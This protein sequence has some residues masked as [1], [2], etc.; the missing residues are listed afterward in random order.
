MLDRAKK[1]IKRSGKNR[2]QGILLKYPKRNQD[3]RIDLPTVGIHTLKKCVSLNLKGIA[4][5]N[6]QNIF[7]DRKKLIDFANKNKIFIE[8]K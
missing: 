1:I 7:I 2:K 4:L 5:K 3:L 6:K 8:V